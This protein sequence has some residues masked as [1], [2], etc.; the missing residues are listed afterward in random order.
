MMQKKKND[1]EPVGLHIIDARVLE[2][3]DLVSTS[4]LTGNEAG[5]CVDSSMK[6]VDTY[7]LC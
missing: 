1:L 5:N 6:S 2:T 7:V 4:F 3:K